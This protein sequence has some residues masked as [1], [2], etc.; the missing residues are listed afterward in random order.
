MQSALC[1][2]KLV[3]YPVLF[4]IFCNS[5]CD[6]IIYAYDDITQSVNVLLIRLQ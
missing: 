6:H 1:N 5:V 2:V 3:I 4:C